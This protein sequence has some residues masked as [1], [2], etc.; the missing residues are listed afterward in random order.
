MKLNQVVSILVSKCFVRLRLGHTMKTN[1]M[2]LQAV[3][4]EISSILIFA[5]KDLGLVFPSYFVDDFSSKIFLMSYFI[6]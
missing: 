6:Y 1:C 5:K 4:P 2:K 3:N